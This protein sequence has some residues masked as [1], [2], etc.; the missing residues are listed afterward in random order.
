M[1]RN[2]FIALGI[3]LVVYVGYMS[4]FT[5]KTDQVPL[6]PVAA[7][8]ATATTA[9][10]VSIQEVTPQ[11]EA[12]KTVSPTQIQQESLFTVQT[13]NADIVL[14]NKGAAIKNFVF[15]DVI[16]PV[17]LT[18]YKGPGFFSTF[19]DLYFAKADSSAD[20]AFKA[21]LAPGVDVYKEYNFSKD[22]K[23]GNV[24]LKIV[25]TTPNDINVSGLHYNFGPGLATVKSEEGDNPA[26]WNAVCLI[27]E[28]GKKKPTVNNITEKEMKDPRKLQDAC[29][30][31][32]WAGISNRY[33]LVALVPQNWKTKAEQ[34][35]FSKQ[36]VYD[37]SSF[38]GLFGTRQI[39]GP[40]LSVALPGVIPAGKEVIY[41]ADFYFGPK[42]YDKFASMPYNLERSIQFG[43]FGQ[44]GKMAHSLLEWLYG[45]TKNYGTAIILMT[46]LIQLVLFPLTYKQLK[47]SAVMQRI[48]P[49]MKRIQEKYKEDPAMQQREMLGLYKKYGANPLSGCLPLFIQFPIFLALFNALRTS[50]SLHG[51]PF[52][53]WIHDLS[54]K[55]PY[56][57]L[58]VAMG[59]MMYIQQ[60]LTMPDMGKDNPSM[61][62]MKWMPVFMTVLFL[63]F[64]AGLTLY[65]FV[66]NCISF[67][68]NLILKRKMK[69]LGEI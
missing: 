67:A 69:T 34:L 24:S 63:N 52:M 4:F 29:A 10:Q 1:D 64:P 66:S 5:P 60:K 47:S 39:F 57:V 42:D 53:W 36:Y 13:K 54:A 11:T 15:K 20:M 16:A 31:W 46:V 33:F 25:N 18:P 61:V 21:T 62:M 19:D 30:D 49:E 26:N 23:I 17:N 68:I 56:Y 27:Q 35:S 38:F 51:A 8:T 55:D 2:F 40:Q 48:Q 41:N 43:F 12:V 6:K 59:V 50:W 65:W 22:G 37:K 44:L 3:A 45:M 9:A 28:Q 32:H 7:A 14:S 58:P